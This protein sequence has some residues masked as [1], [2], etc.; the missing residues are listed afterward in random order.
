[1]IGLEKS[2]H[3]ALKNCT[4][5]AGSTGINALLNG[6]GAFGGPVPGSAKIKNVIERHRA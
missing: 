5:T 3:P 6:S 1:M 2:F 4:A